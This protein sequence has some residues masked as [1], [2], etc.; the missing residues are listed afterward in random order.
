[1]TPVSDWSDYGNAFIQQE[2]YFDVD[3]EMETFQESARET[4]RLAEFYDT[5]NF[6]G[7]EKD[8]HFVFSGGKGFHMVDYGFNVG[9]AYGETT[10]H[11]ALEKSLRKRKK[12]WKV[13]GCRIC[14]YDV[15]S[16]N[17][18]ATHQT[19]PKGRHPTRL[20]GNS[21]PAPY[22]SVT[23]N[24]TRKER[25]YLPNYQQRRTTR[26]RPRTNSLVGGS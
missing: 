11:F 15:E 1:M 14:G 5:L 10:S 22:H 19:H 17:E 18:K 20:R 9:K 2:M 8:I 24:Y 21:R 26:F 3:Y 25:T 4:L 16:E 13:Q 7:C 12:K 23:G 6:N